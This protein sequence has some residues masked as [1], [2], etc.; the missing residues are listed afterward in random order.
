M[1]LYCPQKLLQK[2]PD[3]DKDGVIIPLLF[4]IKFK[5]VFLFVIT[6]V[7][8]NKPI[9][10]YVHFKSILLPLFLFKFLIFE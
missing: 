1:D 8:S 4:N 3:F 7:V 9:I 10:I 2:L 5:S 6:N